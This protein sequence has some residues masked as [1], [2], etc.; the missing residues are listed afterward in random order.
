MQKRGY[1]SHKT[2]TGRVVYD[3]KKHPFSERDVKRIVT[4]WAN[5]DYDPVGGVLRILYLVF[6]IA[7]S[8]WKAFSD[9]KI[10]RFWGQ[11]L[12]AVLAQT[13]AMYQRYAL[14]PL[15]ELWAVIFNWLG[16]PPDSEETTPPV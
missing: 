6:A 9:K 15:L 12:G 14:E 3:R 11:L 16:H 10:A 8:A 1:R 4:G 7:E 2:V 5:L 13:M